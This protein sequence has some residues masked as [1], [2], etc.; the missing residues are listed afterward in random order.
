MSYRSWMRDKGRMGNNSSW[1]WNGS[2]VCGILGDRIVWWHLHLVMR[3][4]YNQI[5]LW[6]LYFLL[7]R[8]GGILLNGFNICSEWFLS[9]S[10][11]LLVCGHN[12]VK[13][14]DSVLLNYKTND[15]LQLWACSLKWMWP[16]R[17]NWM[18]WMLWN[19]T[20]TKQSMCYCCMSDSE[21][22][23][24]CEQNCFN[25]SA[26]KKNHKLISWVTG[27]GLK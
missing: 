8:V 5:F 19:D 10:V 15:V 7:T 23:D 2:M 3:W 24:S 12:T 22:N 13:Y 26:I 18:W 17:K 16:E 1:G 6:S 25:E 4:Y 14:S 21:I 27:I 9:C 11:L 20:K